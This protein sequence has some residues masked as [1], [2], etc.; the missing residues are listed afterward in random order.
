MHSITNTCAP[1]MPFYGEECWHVNHKF[2]IC[3]HVE[4]LDIEHYEASTGDLYAAPRSR[5]G[6]VNTANQ[7]Q[8]GT[9][10][11]TDGK[12]QDWNDT[13]FVSRD[14]DTP[15]PLP[16]IA[17]L[18][19]RLSSVSSNMSLTL[20]P[21]QKVFPAPRFNHSTL[22]L[23]SPYMQPQMSPTKLIFRSRS[24]TLPRL[25][26]GS[27]PSSA[28]RI[29]QY[30]KHQ[31]VDGFPYNV[32]PKKVTSPIV[33]R[34]QTLQHVHSMATMPLEEEPDSFDTQP[35]LNAVHQQL[36]NQ[37]EQYMEPF[38]L[39]KT[40]LQLQDAAF[41]Y[42][43]PVSISPVKESADTNIPGNI[44]T[45]SSSNA[46]QRSRVFSG[47]NIASPYMEPSPV[48]KARHHS[49]EHLFRERAGTGSTVTSTAFVYIPPEVSRFLR[50]QVGV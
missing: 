5:S 13:T 39:Q 3:Y 48:M 32:S 8:N 10:D 36:E 17:P 34:P 21:Q 31:R 33:H 7:Q 4:S 12:V 30:R 25:D 42:A 1:N 40:P 43:D 15:P 19:T 24:T 41:P 23:A 50:T 26:A 27:R 35:H 6:S 29:N 37:A 46:L 11:L 38:K 9:T 18:L 49:S 28:G 47:D 2:V 20:S 44:P 22:T 14:E 16:P 45:V